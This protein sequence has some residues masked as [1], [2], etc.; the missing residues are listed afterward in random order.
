MS[1][2]RCRQ[3][4][5]R[6]PRHVPRRIREYRGDLEDPAVGEELAPDL[7]LLEPDFF[8][9]L[10]GDLEDPAV[11]G[12]MAPDLDAVGPD[13]R[14]HG[15]REDPAVSREKGNP[16]QLLQPPCGAPSLYGSEELGGIHEYDAEHDGECAYSTVCTDMGNLEDHDRLQA[17]LREQESELDLSLEDQ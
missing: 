8:D 14:D 16:R 11:G 4:S 5:T 1:R 17:I 9:D 6:T 13:L 15:G 3:W 2:C 10:R 7:D 12:E